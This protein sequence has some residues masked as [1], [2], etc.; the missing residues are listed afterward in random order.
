MASSGTLLRVALVRT[1]VS[2]K[3]SIYFLRSFRRL[4]VMANVVPSSP[5]LV[6][7]MMEVLSSSDTSVLTRATRRSIP[8]DAT[9]RSQR[10]LQAEKSLRVLQ[11]WLLPL[12]IF[13]GTDLRVE[14]SKAGE[15]LYG[16]LPCLFNSNRRHSAKRVCETKRKTQNNAE[17]M[18]VA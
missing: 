15:Q 10:F 4:L 5:I 9:L 11:M 17:N 6:T 8:E 2:E 14:A 18:A 3:Q 1:D 13:S 7:L 16:S 12:E